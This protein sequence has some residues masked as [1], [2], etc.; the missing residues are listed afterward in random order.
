MTAGERGGNYGFEQDRGL[1]F[2][3]NTA[4]KWKLLEE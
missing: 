2:K 3:V 1:S 4:M